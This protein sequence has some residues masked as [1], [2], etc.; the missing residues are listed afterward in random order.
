MSKSDYFRSIQHTLDTIDSAGTPKRQESVISG[1]SNGKAIISGKEYLVFNSNDYL[2]M[3]FHPGLKQEH[4]EAA[5]LYGEGPGA[6][7]FISGTLQIHKEL[8]KTIAEFHGRD[9]AIVFSSAFAANL[10]LLSALIRPPKDSAISS[11]V[12]VISDALNH[13][14]IIDGIRMSGVPSVQKMIYEHLQYESLSNVLESNTGKFDRVIVVTDG[15]FSMLGEPANLKALREVCDTF[16]SRYQQGVLLVVDDSHGVGVF[17]KTGR[18]CEESFDAKADVLVGTLGKA[19]GVDGGY[20]TACAE[21]I[22]YLRET[23]STYIYSN[24]LSP[25]SAAAARLSISIVRS[26]EGLGLLQQLEQNISYFRQRM[27]AAGFEFRYDSMHPIQPLIIGDTQKT[28]IFAQKMFD[29]GILVTPITYPVVPEGKDEIR[30]QL[31][32]AHAQ[33]DLD[34]FVKYAQQFS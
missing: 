19:F 1:Y 31:S 22:K 15:I 16:D 26:D 30:V 14:S 17:G 11:N 6:V 12:L 4:H 33:E 29:S 3:R 32:S 27:H 5:D 2:Y 23:A 18:G 21:I 20:I 34:S 7:R 24:A 13:R 8:E 10:G 9:D 25:G 28:R